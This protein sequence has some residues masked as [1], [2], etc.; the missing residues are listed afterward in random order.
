MN[1]RYTKDEACAIEW[2]SVN[3]LAEW[4]AQGTEDGEKEMT[5][6]EWYKWFKK[7]IRRHYPTN[8]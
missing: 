2:F 1:Y 5:V 3:S 8:K 7:E 6:L 4:I